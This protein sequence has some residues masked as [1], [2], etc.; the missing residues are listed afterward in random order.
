MSGCERT[1]SASGRLG[2]LFA[3]CRL[4]G[5]WK[6]PF[7]A[8]LMFVP[9]L[10]VTSFFSGCD[11]SATKVAP[12]PAS[13]GKIA[14]VDGGALWTRPL[15]DG[16]PR[17]VTTDSSVSQPKWSPSGQWLLYRTGED[18]RIVREDGSVARTIAGDPTWAPAA[19]DL[20]TGGGDVRIQHA[21][22]SGV[23][24][25]VTA[26]SESGS[27]TT[28]HDLSWSSDG[29]WL[30]YVERVTS[31]D[32]PQYL[33]ERLMKVRA[34]GTAPS[35]LYD[36]GWPAPEGLA[37]RGW[38]PDDGEL[39]V[40]TYPSFSASAAADG[41]GLLEVDASGGGTPHGFGFADDGLLTFPT[42]QSWGV[43]GQLAVT[44]GGG[45]DTWTHK[46]IRIVEPS[47]AYHVLTDGD[48]AAT[49]PAFSPDARRVAFVAM[50]DAGTGV[51]GGDAARTALAARKIRLVD[52]S[53]A[54]NRQI[55][56]NAAYRDEYPQWAA[57]GSR[58]L[59]VR[60]DAQSKA[61]L[62][63]MK[64]DGGDLHEVLA[65]FDASTVQSDVPWLGYYGH[66]SWDNV[67]DWWR[68]VPS[69]ATTTSTPPSISRSTVAAFREDGSEITL[70]NPDG[71]TPLG[72]VTAGYR[73]SVVVRSRADQALIS[74]AFGP[75][76]D[77][78]TPTLSVYS[79]HDLT[80]PILTLA[81]P[82]RATPVVYYPVMLLSADE[83]FLYY[84]KIKS[85]CPGGEACD[86]PSVGVIDLSR[87]QEVGVA[88]LPVGCS[89]PELTR[90]GTSDALATCQKSSVILTRVSAFG[91]AQEVARFPMRIDPLTTGPA[92]PVLAD[93]DRDGNYYVLYRDGMLLRSPDDPGT[94]LINRPGDI[95]CNTPSLTDTELW[96]AA[97]GSG[98][99]DYTG[100]LVVSRENPS[101]IQTIP[102]AQPVVFVTA[103]R[104]SS[105]LLLRRASSQAEIFDVT[106]RAVVRDD[107]D[108]P[109]GADVLAGR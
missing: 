107:V 93:Q 101:E 102:L 67:L 100:L 41:L 1:D 72:H 39:L 20:A 43:N 25:L 74:Q 13:L 68:G 7:A 40:W 32:P 8:V 97:Y 99:G 69:A 27:T 109:G 16:S 75:G 44:G 54:N 71:G 64:P 3:P 77:I 18:R 2:R 46:E 104:T 14:Y 51:S 26:S 19:D 105:V 30:A 106:S 57:D 33:S 49:E 9:A 35:L 6:K 56:S 15:P 82:D 12:G 22:G 61:S 98:D 70:L 88:A 24:T 10:V 34:D 92:H 36:P 5:V 11:H 45:R 48:T 78:A 83:Q 58:L 55:T 89:F 85:G 76:P 17:R 63:M 91:T 90:I 50:P 37:I 73:P 108:V 86:L 60:L 66:I 94:R 103:W 87:D 23:Q 84:V 96:V 65:D 59:F 21:D 95:G 62:W 52:V 79:L 42:F 28:F 80:A 47:G 31:A 81:M 4:R 38:S 53:G 29:K